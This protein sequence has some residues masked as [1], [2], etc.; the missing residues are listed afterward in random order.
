MRYVLSL[1]LL[2]HGVAHL[3]GFVV[4]WRLTTLKEMAYKTTILGGR[5]DL[6]EAG[7]GVVG[8]LWLIA[9]AA[10]VAAA[11]ACVFQAPWALPFTLALSGA[12]L[13][14]CAIEWPEARIGVFVNIGLLLILL[15]GSRLGLPNQPGH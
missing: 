4:P 13:L 2:A 9:A 15:L 10:F 3:V 7:I 8:L 6:G 11:G 5:V 12:S 1:F 14:L